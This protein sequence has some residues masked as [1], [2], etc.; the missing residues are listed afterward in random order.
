MTRSRSKIFT[1]RRLLRK[2]N[3]VKLIIS[4][5]LLF[6]FAVNASPQDPPWVDT[7]Q[8]LRTRYVSPTGTGVGTEADPMALSTAISTALPGDLVRL[9][10]GT[11]TG[12]F[13]PTVNGTALN[14]IVFRSVADAL[15]VINGAF[16]NFGNYNWI[17]GL[18][19]IDPGGLAPTPGGGA[20]DALATGVHVINNVIHNL[21]GKNGIT[22]FVFGPGVVIYGNIVYD[23][24]STAHGIYTQNNFD[25]HGFKYIVN[26]IFVDSDD[27]CNTCFNFH[28]YTEG[29]FIQGFHVQNN[30]ISNGRF[31]IGG[32]NEP[33][34]RSVVVENYF[35]DS[36]VKFG[37]RRPTQADFIDNY[38]ARTTLDIRWFWGEPEVLF[39]QTAPN[40]FTGNEIVLPPPLNG[41]ITHIRF[42]T[43]AFG[44]GGRCEGCPA[45]QA[46]DTFNNNIYQGTFSATFFADNNNLGTVN[47]ATWQSATASAG[48]AFDVNST[49]GGAAPTGSKIV[50][51]PNEY[52]SGRAHLAIYNWDGLAEV[53]VDLSSIVPEGTLFDVYPAK[54]VLGEAV[55]SGTYSAP[56]N[57]PTGGEEFSIYLVIA[58]SGSLSSPKGLRVVSP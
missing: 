42:R 57:V 44:P 1:L 8:T 53:A 12:S 27:I 17:W 7:Y 20:V 11:Y 3:T 16:S 48:N 55:V 41:N 40:V 51:L 26:N 23:Q 15:V 2:E 46:A 36:S 49:V 21:L 30:I 45:I 43:S 25:L 6:L 13:Q 54:D 34:D 52:E 22:A 33:A 37:Y 29:G 31:L 32:F 24:G 38:L 47:F 10:A 4:S 35:Y 50:L 9:N 56:I 5:L 28:A 14:P 19:V 39:T 58:H 18:D